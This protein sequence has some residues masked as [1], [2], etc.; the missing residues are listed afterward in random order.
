M[1]ER[2]IF[3]KRFLIFRTLFGVTKSPVTSLHKVR[4]KGRGTVA[5]MSL[6]TDRTP[7]FLLDAM[8][9]G[10]RE[11]KSPIGFFQNKL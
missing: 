4:G 6:P 2:D 8:I 10:T 7:E 11:M 9:G 1:V 3:Q 5:S